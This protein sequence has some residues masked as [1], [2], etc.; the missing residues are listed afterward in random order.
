MI[1]SIH[2]LLIED[3]PADADL[4][5]ESLE[6]SRFN[7]EI[8]V[9]KDGEE[10]IEFLGNADGRPTMILLDLNLP[11]KDG[12]QVLAII[13]SDDV[14]RRIPILVLSS[15]DS[16]KDITSCY[17][18]GANCYITKPADL[19]AYRAIVGTLEE[20]WFNTATLPARIGH[21]IATRVA[22]GL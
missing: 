6:A 20:F 8:S 22:Y 13:K 15:S 19:K 3:N 12:R 16:E 11:R 9:A 2:V 1:K 7:I 18:L 17:E 5:R 4:T 14:L 10:A 21:T